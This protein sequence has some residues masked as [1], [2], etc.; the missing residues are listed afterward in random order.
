MLSAVHRYLSRL[1]AAGVFLLALLVL[2]VVGVA[3]YLTGPETSVVF[4]YLV[5]VAFGTWY[6]SRAAGM[7]LAIL[8]AVIAIATD[9]ASGQPYSHTVIPFW[10]G[11]L[12]AAFFTAGVGLLD[13]LRE[14]LHVEQKL[15]RTDPLTG[16]LNSRAFVEHMGYIIALS[17]RDGAP[18]TLAYID[19]D[20]FKQINDTRGHSAGDKVLRIVGHTLRSSIRRTDAVARLGGDEFALLLPVTNQEAA[21]TLIGKIKLRLTEALALHSFPVGCSIGAV[22]FREPPASPDEA[23]RIADRVMYQAKNQGKNAIVFEAVPPAA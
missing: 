1:P 15:A 7:T 17:Q 3:D 12:Q 19:L 16:I 22:T 5:P 8:S 4:L 21:R 11:L 23:I 14:R 6:G 18:I 13:M 20:D 9:L 2:S 10:N